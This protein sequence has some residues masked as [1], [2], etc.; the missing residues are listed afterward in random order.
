MYENS[1]LLIKTTQVEAGSIA[2]RSPSN[3][4]IIKYW[5][6]FGRQYPRNPS[7]SFTLSQAYT[8]TR[9][10]YCA[11][12][13][14]NG[15][16]IAL[17]FTFE[18]QKNTLFADKLKRFLA[19]ITDIFPFIKQLHFM[20]ESSNSFPHSSGIA[21]S[22]S[23]MSALAY[24]L[25]DMEQKLF[26]DIK[27]ESA[28]KRKASYVARLGSGSACRSVY[29]K[30]A[31]WGEA[32]GIPDSSNDYAIP[33]AHRLHPDF[34]GMCDSVLIVSKAEKSVSSRA[35]HAL[36]E[37]NPYANIRYRQANERLADLVHCLE[38][39]DMEG[40]IK[41][42]E[43]EALS[44]H[45]LMMTSEPSYIL[46]KPATLAVIDKIRDFRAQTGLPVCFT[47]D[48][49]PNVH[50]LYP[51]SAKAKVDAFIASELL[52]HCEDNYMIADQI[53]DGPVAL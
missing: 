33:W 1:D 53:G 40:F 32:E 30:A 5:G 11:K 22:A 34:E 51:Q 52:P 38:T 37:G 7:I 47:L 3:I 23:S 10:G 17:D 14:Q 19:S 31:L 18:G 46:V 27:N 50:V 48:A 6:K 15:E 36:M 49:G 24:G 8:D 35:G 4:A 45:A 44:L 13:A 29:A 12:S 28:L 43:N 26:G 20:I 16:D 25:C 39:G 21:S 9:I 2:W 42:S 41:I